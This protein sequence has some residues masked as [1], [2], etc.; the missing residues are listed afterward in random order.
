MNTITAWITNIIILILLATILE[1]LLPN[2]HMQRY[3]KLVVGLLLLMVMIH[4]LLS[5]FQVD[6]EEWLADLAAWDTAAESEETSFIESKKMD[7]EKEGLAYISEQAAVL[8]REQASS[9]LEKRFEVVPLDVYIEF[10]PVYEEESLSLIKTE[11]LLDNLSGVYVLLSPKDEE[12]AQR[13]GIAVV[14]INPVKIEKADGDPEEVEEAEKTAEIRVFLAALWEIPEEK[15]HVQM[16]GG[17][18]TA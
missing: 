13:E 9:E 3:V 15:I 8:L 17:E 7:I 16:K 10:E 12:D 1:L 11:D 6:P 18:E 5:I 4:P 2:S 14:E